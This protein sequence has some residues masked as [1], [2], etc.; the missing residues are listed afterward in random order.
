M[1]HALKFLEQEFPDK[2]NRPSLTH[3]AIKALGETA[4]VCPDINGKIAFGRFVPYPTIDISCL[5][6]VGG[7]NDLAMTL[8]EGVDKMSLEDIGD[9]IKQKTSKIRG[10]EG[11]DETHKKRTGPAKWMPVFLISIVTKLMAFMT[12]TLGIDLGVL[13][14]KKNPFGFGMLT[15]VGMLGFTDAIAPFTPFS[16]CSVIVSV[17]KVIE[18]PVA[19]N[20]EVKVEKVV[21][22]NF[23]V[24][25]RYI[26]GGKAAKMVPAFERVFSE[27][28]LFVRR[29]FK[30]E[31]L[32]EKDK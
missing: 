2:K 27:P 12:S 13:G 22:I 14:M 4:R 23:T 16:K 29:N 21:N 5:V 17:N 15:S 25:H 19:V 6:D 11:G 30:L 18:K 10:T 1:E 3:L 24:D 7:G 26:D 28:E 31:A 8:I 9:Y 20:G 32:Q